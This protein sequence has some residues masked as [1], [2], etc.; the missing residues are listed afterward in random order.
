[1][2]KYL[3]VFK[4]EVMTN[5]QYVFNLLF[6][7][8]GYAIMLFILYNM[9]K[10]LYS[11]PSELING[12]SYSQM[13]WYVLLTEVMWSSVGGRKLCRKITEDV[14][15]GNIA[16]NIS[17]PYS[18]I[19][20]ILS[21]HM[22]DVVVKGIFYFAIS[23]ILG[24]AF[25]GALPNITLVQLVFVLISCLLANVISIFILTFIGLFSFYIEDSGPFYWVYSKLIL[26]FSTIFP[27][28]YFP[29]V[30]QPILKLSPAYVVSYGPAKLYVDFSWNNLA[31]I[32][33]AQ[34]IYI[35]IT[36]LL[37]SL[38]YRK[39]VKKLSVNGG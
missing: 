16:Y 35:L 2:K 10:Y 27:I 14:K 7:F 21:N 1:M 29:K 13:I 20:Y 3:Y 36:Y 39:G 37:C 26:V 15:S 28:E 34:I 22:A 33:F 25:L 5:F 6:G 19:G 31:V 23:I 17:K 9:Y 32:L 24:V 8:V 4:S 12:Y 18:Y 38:I 30:M 11:D